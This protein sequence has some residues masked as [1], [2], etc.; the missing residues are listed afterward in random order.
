M[1]LAV[2]VVHQIQEEDVAM[3]ILQEATGFVVVGII[4]IQIRNLVQT[5]IACLILVYQSV[6]LVLVAIVLLT[7][8]VTRT[9]I[10][11]LCTTDAPRATIPMKTTNREDA[12]PIGCHVIRDLSEIQTFQS[13]AAK[14]GF[15]E[16]IH[17]YQYAEHHCH[18]TF[19]ENIHLHGYVGITMVEMMT[20]I[21]IIATTIIMTTA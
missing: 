18:L 11:S 13:V 1:P 9:A 15:A 16:S 5:V 2:Q 8:V 7:L 21:M 12:Y 19:A 14:I 4:Q 3:V 6:N 20:M 10:V 17:L